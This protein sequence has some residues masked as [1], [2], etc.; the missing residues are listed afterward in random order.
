MHLSF[1]V[2]RCAFSKSRKYLIEKNTKKTAK[3][4][5][6]FAGSGNRAFQNQIANKTF[7]IQVNY[8]CPSSS[9]A[10]EVQGQLINCKKAVSFI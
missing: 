3:N 5:T 9:P 10:P 8:F 6:S 2:L 7:R 1:R 4:L